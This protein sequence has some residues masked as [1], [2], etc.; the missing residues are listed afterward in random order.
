MKHSGEGE[1][2]R[3]KELE[4]GN[5][6]QNCLPCTG[7]AKENR[8]AEEGKMPVRV[9]VSGDLDL[10]IIMVNMSGSGGS[11]SSSFSVPCCPGIKDSV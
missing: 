4:N 11:L 7:R 2:E 8:E 9:D 1:R 6:N 10:P 5:W 3:K